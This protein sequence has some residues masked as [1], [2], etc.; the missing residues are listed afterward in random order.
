MCIFSKSFSLMIICTISLVI[1]S[2]TATFS[3][4]DL[5]DKNLKGADLRGADLKW[6]DLR[7]ADLRG[8]DLTGADL[9]GAD[10]SYAN[11]RWADLSYANLENI[12]LENAEIEGI[13][14]FGA[15]YEDYSFRHVFKIDGDRDWRSMAV[16]KDTQVQ[17]QNDSNYSTSLKEDYNDCKIYFSPRYDRTVERDEDFTITWSNPDTKNCTYD[18]SFYHADKSSAG[19]WT[20]QINSASVSWD[21]SGT[22][23]FKICHENECSVFYKFEL[24]NTSIDCTPTNVKLSEKIERDEDFTITWS[25]PDT[26]NC[27]YDVSFYHADKSSAGLVTDEINSVSGSWNAIGT[28]FFKICPTNVNDCKSPF[29]SITVEDRSGNIMFIILGIAVAIVILIVFV[30]KR[31]TRKKSPTSSSTA[32]PSSTEEIEI[33][34]MTDID[35]QIARNEEKIRKIEEENKRPDEED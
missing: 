25:N 28:K 18:V 7:G 8:A 26:K 10:L 20:D 35:K 16:F 33:D 13:N 3:Y 14:L 9:T 6:A 24:V 21:S 15:T 11:L 32:V 22:K 4:A 31:N 29:Y 2:N 34:K 30:S 1:I 23:F 19:V 12:K 27:I 5:S 17:N